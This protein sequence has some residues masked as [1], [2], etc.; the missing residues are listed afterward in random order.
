MATQ[1]QL[2]VQDYPILKPFRLNGRWYFPSDKTISLKPAQ[3]P[4]LLKNGKIGLAEQATQ[5]KQEVI[6]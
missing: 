6:K 4:F 1:K 5:V 2:G 3:T